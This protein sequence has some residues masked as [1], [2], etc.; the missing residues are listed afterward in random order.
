M[1]FA[2]CMSGHTMADTLLKIG[3]SSCFMYP[4]MNR[5]TFGP[6]TLC[7]YERDMSRYLTRQNVMTI[8]IPD[9]NDSL[10]DMYFSQVD[11]FVLQGGSDVSPASY[12]SEM[13]ENG[14]WPGDK[15][16]DDYELKLT[17]IAF[18]KKIP[19]LGIC[20]GMQLLNVYFGGTLY[21]DIKTQ[22]LES[23]E[24]RNALEYDKI[25]HD[26][27]LTGPC[28]SEIYPDKKNISVNSIHHQGIDILGKNLTVEARSLEDGIIEAFSY[29]GENSFVLGVQWHPE[30]SQTLGNEVAN[31]RNIYDYFLSKVKQN[32]HN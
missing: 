3:V 9:V 16:R 11:G 22:V 32:A 15:Y 28:L 8:L 24:H 1:T 20:R 30:F 23:Q 17:K 29:S 12:N 13:I 6:K 27:N 14:R 31:P 2:S 5:P 25:K 26:V 18:E 19:I 10:L 21:Q 4:D 7:F